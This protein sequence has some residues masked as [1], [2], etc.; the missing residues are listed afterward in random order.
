[1]AGTYEVIE[2][3]KDIYYLGWYNHIN[4]ITAGL[5]LFSLV[6]SL[7]FSLWYVSEMAGQ[8]GDSFFEEMAEVYFSKNIAHSR[9]N[10]SR[11]IGKATFATLVHFFIFYMEVFYFAKKW[12]W[13]NYFSPY[14]SF[15]SLASTIASYMALSKN[16]VTKGRLFHLI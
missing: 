7:M 14:C 16:N 10:L 6:G 2:I 5:L 11:K 1:M 13:F 8:D 3:A 4:G 15:I 9:K 12:T